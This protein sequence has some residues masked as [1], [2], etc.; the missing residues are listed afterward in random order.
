MMQAH[1]DIT[2]RCRHHGCMRTT[3]TIDDDILA[4]AKSV[5]R[6]RSLP[7]GQV[8]SDWARRGLQATPKVTAKGPSGFPV[9]ETRPGSLPVTL[10]DVRKL[11]DE[12]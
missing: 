5:A 6:A 2:V 1:L 12:P 3:L 11:E 10:E 8:L 7:V 9:F 4:A